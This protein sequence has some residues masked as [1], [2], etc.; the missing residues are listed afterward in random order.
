VN[1]QNSQIPAF[2][3]RFSETQVTKQILP[4]WMQQVM[5]R[6]SGLLGAVDATGNEIE[7]APKGAIMNARLLWSLSFAYVQT[8]DPRYFLSAA[9]CFEGF[10]E[11]FVDRKHGGI[12]WSL[13]AVN[14]PLDT[15]KQL[16]AQT[17]TIYALAQYYVASEDPSA[18]R[19]AHTLTTQLEQFFKREDNTYCGHLAQNWSTLD[20]EE[21][22]F[23]ETCNQ[24]HVLEA[25][26]QLYLVDPNPTLKSRM[27]TLIDLFLIH[28]FPSGSHLGLKFDR[29]WNRVGEQRS[30]GHNFEAPWL[31]AF[32][33]DLIEDSVRLKLAN[34][35]LKRLVDLTLDQGR[36]LS[37]SV[38]FGCDEQGKEAD[39][40]MWWPQTEAS[41]ALLWLFNSTEDR[42]YLNELIDLWQEIKT[43]WIDQENGEWHTEL[44]LNM[45]PSRNSNKADIWRSAYHST[46]ACFLLATGMSALTQT[47]NTIK[48]PEDAPVSHLGSLTVGFNF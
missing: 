30:Y 46:R 13:T 43:K 38:L 14:Q 6:N 23:T 34:I 10:M 45:H 32:A 24:L 20:A 5:R 31:I 25:L 3:T 22:K 7:N 42:R 37:G 12:F 26:S 8:A 29:H 17:Y 44:D 40:L 4:F 48:K 39:I 47:Q 16:L 19:L 15:H 35:E 9:H 27:T 21:K 1:T 28:I 11:H 18:L 36:H 33:C 2:L 41:N